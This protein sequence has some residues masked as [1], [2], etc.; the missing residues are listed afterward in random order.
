MIAVILKLMMFSFFID[1]LPSLNFGFLKFED[2]SV[3][4]NW[5]S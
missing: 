4:F 1:I 3:E 5:H 2:L